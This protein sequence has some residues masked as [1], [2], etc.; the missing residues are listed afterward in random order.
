MATTF[1]YEPQ[2]LLSGW[3]DD[4]GMSML[5][6]YDRDLA[7]TVV[8]LAYAE[9]PFVVNVS[10]FFAPPPITVEVFAPFFVNQS[11]TFHPL[12]VRALKPPDEMLRNEVRRV[13]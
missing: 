9:A 6:W 4:R 1:V 7:G 3:Y 5:S 12:A 13:R 2:Y 10:T 11:L 8:T